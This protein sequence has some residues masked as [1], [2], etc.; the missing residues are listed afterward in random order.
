M[1]DELGLSPAD[2]LEEAG[3]GTSY[4]AEALARKLMAEDSSLTKT[5][6][7]KAAKELLTPY[8]SAPQTRNILK[9]KH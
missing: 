3:I 9:R 1:A 5:A 4:A 6:A 8:T 7:V 2:L